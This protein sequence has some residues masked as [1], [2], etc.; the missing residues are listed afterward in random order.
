MI[1]ME[2][3]CFGY[4]LYHNV[5]ENINLIIEDGEFVFIIGKSGAGKSS[6]FKLLSHEHKPTSGKLIVKVL[7]LIKKM[8]LN[9]MILIMIIKFLI[10]F[11][12]L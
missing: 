12:L 5:L 7:V 2:D 3:I 4:D 10:K 6:L 8:T 9:I 1:R 11:F